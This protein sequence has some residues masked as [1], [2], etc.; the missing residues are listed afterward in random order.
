MCIVPCSLL[1]WCSWIVFRWRTWYDSGGPDHRLSRFRLWRGI[2]DL[3]TSMECVSVL[4]HPEL[5]N[6]KSNI[7]NFTIWGTTIWNKIA[8][9]WPKVAYN[10]STCVVVS[11][12]DQLWPYLLLYYQFWPILANSDK[13]RLIGI[14]VQSNCE[15][16]QEWPVMIQYV[17]LR[18]MNNYGHIWQQSQFWSIFL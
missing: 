3:H 17:L 10:G 14:K 1:L 7:L 4:K 15:N 9:I 8:Q 5:R 18:G 13:F 6:L 11:R 12:Y 2:Q 16:C